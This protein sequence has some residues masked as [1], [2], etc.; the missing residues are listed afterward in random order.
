VIYY[1]LLY[2]GV[3]KSFILLETAVFLVPF[4]T[5][6]FFLTRFLGTCKAAPGYNGVLD[7]FF[8]FA[9]VVELAQSRS[10]CE[11]KIFRFRI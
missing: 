10:E 8:F 9:I 5:V 1:S 2:S 3:I 6:L 4:E 7:F 11:L